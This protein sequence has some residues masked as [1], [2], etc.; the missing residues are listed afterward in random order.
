MINY[1]SPIMTFENGQPIVLTSNQILQPVFRVV[2]MNTTVSVWNGNTVVLGG[3][4]G[5]DINNIGD[6][7]PLFGDLPFLGS[8]FRSKVKEQRRRALILFVSVKVIDPGG[9]PISGSSSLLVEDQNWMVH[10]GR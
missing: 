8:L 7:T 5:D 4:L 3:L 10:I 2:Q 1:G 6:K 9:Q